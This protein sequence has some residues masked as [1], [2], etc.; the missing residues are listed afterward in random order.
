ML[1]VGGVEALQDLLGLLDAALARQRLGEYKAGVGALGT[2]GG[3]GQAPGQAVVEPAE[4][5]AGEA[6]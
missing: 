4:R 6:Q 1:G 2:P 5:L 3:E